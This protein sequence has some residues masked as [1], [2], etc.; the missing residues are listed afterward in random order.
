MTYPGPRTADYVYYASGN[1]TSMT[2]GMDETTDSYNGADQLTSVTPPGESAV[3]YS[4]E[5]NSI[6]WTW[7][8]SDG[9]WQIADI[10]KRNGQ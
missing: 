1:R 5:G 10:D 9:S 7:L 8:E 2:V 3:S 4:W 6:T